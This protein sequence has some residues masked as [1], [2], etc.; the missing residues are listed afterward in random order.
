MKIEYVYDKQRIRDVRKLSLMSG[1]AKRN[2][3]SNSNDSLLEKSLLLDASVIITGYEKPWLDRSAISLD[4]VSDTDHEK[5]EN[6]ETALDC[7]LNI[8]GNS[9]QNNETRRSSLMSIKNDSGIENS[10]T[11][12]KSISITQYEKPWADR[13]A[14]DLETDSFSEQCVDKT[15]ESNTIEKVNKKEKIELEP[16]RSSQCHSDIQQTARDHERRKT[17]K[18]K[19]QDDE[20]DS[21]QKRSNRKRKERSRS[22]TPIH[23]TRRKPR[24]YRSRSSETKHRSRSKTPMYRTRRQTSRYRSRSNET[25]HRSRSKTPMYRTRR[26]TR[27]FQ[28]RSNE[29]IHRSRSKTPIQRSK[30]KK[31]R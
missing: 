24:R 27:S 15:T 29:T 13:S 16:D 11:I 23:R 31:R 21:K 10:M 30:R 25:K 12:D 20:S 19:H 8:R 1:Q 14:I 18:H 9:E 7:N 6:N 22:N 28:S 3:S 5:I 17:R 26:Q 2:S 4:A